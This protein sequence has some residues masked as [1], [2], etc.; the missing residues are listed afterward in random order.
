MKFMDDITPAIKVITDI[1]EKEYGKYD[2]E[3]SFRSGMGKKL[4]CTQFS[5]DGFPVEICLS[6]NLRINRFPFTLMHELAHVHAG[7]SNR[8][9]KKWNETF[10]NIIWLVSEYYTKNYNHK[11]TGE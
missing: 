1:F 11:I 6:D 3:I 9:N 5:E 8:H 4:G 2:I 7:F 10:N